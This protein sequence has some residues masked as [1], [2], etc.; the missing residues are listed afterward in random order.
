[1]GNPPIAE[2]AL[3]SE[4]FTSRL[5]TALPQG[6]S[7][8]DAVWAERHR[9]ILILLWL[10]VP[11]L[12]V[13][14][15]V[16][17][18]TVLHSLFEAGLV[19]NFPLAAEV[20][21]RRRRL[22]TVIASLGLL[23]CSA[24]L[25]HLSG[26]VIE[27][28][29]H[30]FVMVGVVTLYQDW[31]PF[32]LAIAYVVLQHGV[33][34]AIAPGSVFNHKSAV[35][36]P[37]TWAGIHGA[38]IGAMSFAAIA[39]W[40]FNEL[41]WKATADR[42]A[43][44]SEAQEVARLGSWEY[45]L[46]TGRLTWSEELY[47]LFG[48]DRETF[49]P[50]PEAILDLVHP[51]DREALGGQ[52]ETAFAGDVSREIDFRVPLPD[53]TDRWLHRRGKVSPSANGRAAVASGTLADVTDRKRAA[54]ELERTLSLLSATLD[55]TAD[56][57]L[58]VGLDGRITLFN[59]RFVDMWR[60]P[61]DV[62]AS[63]DDDAALG[64]VLEQLRDPAEFVAKVRELYAHPDI[65]SFDTLNFRDGRVVERSSK[66]QRVEGATVGRVWSFRD[67]TD[68]KRLEAE[69]AHQ[70]FHDSLTALANQALFRDR[71]DHAVARNDRLIA[72][73]AV[74]FLDLDNFK[75][76]ND[77]LGHTAGDEVLVAVAER[78]GR[79]VRDSDT[80]ARL[81]GDEFAV[82]LED[83]AMVGDVTI[84]AERIIAVLERPF[85]LAG[86]EV[87]IGASIGI[88]L[89]GPGIDGGQL[90]R[91]AD[92]A[93]YT[94]KRR[95]KGRYE[96][97]QA[98]MH[99]AAVDRMELEADLRKALE[100]RELT[101]EYQPV[102]AVATGGLSGVEALVRWC[103]PER[104]WVP[105]STFI[106]LAEEAG[107]IGELGRQVL[108]A[109]CIQ[110]RSWQLRY[111]KCADLHM[112]VNLSPRQLQSDDLIAEVSDALTTYGLPPSTLVLEI[113]E[114]AMMKD[115]EAAIV[116]LHGLKAL[117]V[118]LAVDD[119]GT[120]YSSLSYLQRFPI[121]ILKIDRAF[122]NGIDAKDDQASLVAAIV[123]LAQSLRLSAVA[124]GV[125]TATQADAL[126]ALGCAFAQ[127]YHFARPMDP[128]L[129]TAMLES[130]FVPA[131]VSR[132]PAAH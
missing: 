10:H 52:M 113:T 27:A 3:S 56:A 13:F 26:G 112:S 98:A 103:H 5:R 47:R 30:Y 61:D 106:P 59:R 115:A 80:V 74:I 101:L 102:V 128:S 120:G 6:R 70:A 37:W 97:F 99:L 116:K 92:I 72:R 127:G 66:P 36:H 20:F 82:L 60:I 117:G 33:A 17:H 44:L 110:A 76:V 49:T 81:G 50:T 95:G 64:C 119:F 132:A 42:E 63:N 125:E 43:Q 78:L 51:A 53:G 90:L 105:P 28:H 91:N 75:T 73:L 84:L 57:L 62:L 109:A 55:S 38:F 69:L 45:D 9:R 94:A 46:A 65:E 100:R 32:L 48:V 19:A 122:V 25:V 11:G 35:D 34:G 12:L 118:K 123:A 83:L 41:L 15:L 88:A 131:A 114:G 104:G 79:C 1:M 130:G 67:I 21:R 87:F 129:L 85:N 111:P 96:I 54:A 40:K 68:T 31:W 14:A 124:E 89:D 71:V 107:L 29:F 8:P 58:V 22:A 2:A 23:T 18:Q 93:M 108:T 77:S 121:D 126:A 86:R 4:R 7:L 39:S 16:R 24:E